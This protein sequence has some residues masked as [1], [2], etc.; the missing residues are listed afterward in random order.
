MDT[1]NITYRKWSSG[2]PPRPIKL[3]VPG[4]AGEHNKHT[5]GDAPQPWHCL[6]FVEGSTYGLELCYSFEGES[7]VSMKDG[8]LLFEGDCVVDNPDAPGKKMPLFMAFAP[9]HFGTTSCL[10]IHVPPG[11]VLRTEPHPRFYTD[12]T[13]SVP[14]CVPGHLQTQWWPMIFFLVFKNP[15]PGQTLVFKKGQP[16]AQV[17]VVPKKVGYDIQEMS[18]QE[19]EERR[20]IGNLIRQHSKQFVKNDW[21]DN[22]GGHFDD[23]YKILS[24][25]YAKSGADGV[26]EFLNSF[27]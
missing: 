24:A 13:S 9:H 23:K 26:K 5:N 25:I 2:I 19:Q 15:M 14:C 16:Y 27:S 4:W 12:T 10:D 17:L 11:Y 20:T 3:E 1:I 8:Q 6:P 18:Q 22:T 21:C 7:R